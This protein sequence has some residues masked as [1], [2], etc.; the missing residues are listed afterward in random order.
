MLASSRLRGIL[1]AVTSLF[2]LLD[3][4]D[5]ARP[6]YV[7]PA[8]GHVSWLQR[9]RRGLMLTAKIVLAGA[10]CNVFGNDVKTLDLAVTYET[11]ACAPSPLH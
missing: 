4:V 7:N 5:V 10:L 6:E 9:Y 11:G 1:L 2:S 3:V 8:V